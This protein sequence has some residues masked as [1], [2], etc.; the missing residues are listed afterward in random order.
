MEAMARLTP[1]QRI[2]R[3]AARQHGVFT[4]PDALKAGA[5]PRVIQHRLEMRRWRV[6]HRGV[7][8]LVGAPITLQQRAMAACLAAGPRAVASHRTAGALLGLCAAGDLT[9]ASVPRGTRRARPGLR[10]HEVADLCPGDLGRVEGIPV[11]SPTRTLLDLAGTVG[12]AELEHV[13]ERALTRR[14]TTLDRL[15]RRVQ[16]VAEGGRPGIRAL[17]DLIGPLQPG[18]VPESATEWEFLHLFQE[19]GLIS[20]TPQVTVKVGT[21]TYRLDFADEARLVGVEIDGA[22]HGLASRSFRD[23]DREEALRANGWQILRFRADDRRRPG[24]VTRRV[25]AVL[26]RVDT[27]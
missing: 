10:I 11:T 7:Y 17:R 15:Y 9:E 25:S 24:E 3:V 20:L 23:R 26:A 19:A 13:V 16:R 2:A 14:L 6:I 12:P 27:T 21:R 1:D 22:H 5:S 8:G 4:R 18:A